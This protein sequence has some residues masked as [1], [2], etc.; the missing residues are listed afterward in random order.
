M[1]SI[2]I[3]DLPCSVHVDKG[4][5]VSEGKVH[6]CPTL[7]AALCGVLFSFTLFIRLSRGNCVCLYVLFIDLEIP[8]LRWAVI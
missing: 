4:G 3:I 5:A 7:S 8:I 6:F 1:I 2:M